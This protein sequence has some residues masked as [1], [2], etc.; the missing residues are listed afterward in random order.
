MSLYGASGRGPT[1][2]G[3]IRARSMYP[4]V[5]IYIYPIFNIL[6]YIIASKIMCIIRARLNPSHY[7]ENLRIR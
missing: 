6:F 1:Y 3:S 7:H 2:V 5:C 4:Y